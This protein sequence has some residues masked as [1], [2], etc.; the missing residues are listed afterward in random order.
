MPGA[1][2]YIVASGCP[3]LE[4][5][6]GAGPLSLL[7]GLAAGGDSWVVGDSVEAG[8]E[9]RTHSQARVDVTPNH[10]PGRGRDEAGGLQRY[11]HWGAGGR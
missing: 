6:P 7:L 10:C 5:A 8:G 3:S 1:G 9:S 11:S 4:L 2:L